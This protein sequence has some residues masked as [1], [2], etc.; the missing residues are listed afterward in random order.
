MS[1]SV[2]DL[3]EEHWDE[4]IK[5]QLHPGWWIQ[6]MELVT[7]SVEQFCPSMKYVCHLLKKNT[8]SIMMY[9]WKNLDRSKIISLETLKTEFGEQMATCL[10]TSIPMEDLPMLKNLLTNSI[11][12]EMDLQENYLDTLLTRTTSTSGTTAPI[13]TEAADVT[14]K[15]NFLRFL[16]RNRQ[17][18]DNYEPLEKTGY[19]SSYISFTENGETNKFGSMEYV[20]DF[21]YQV[22]A[23]L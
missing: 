1:Y 17:Q 7:Q 5:L 18:D 20:E 21:L 14:G 16:K 3:L 4:K 6:L 22:R 9:W 23:S 2:K 11:L 13:A 15:S 12:L 19:L 8:Q 10:N